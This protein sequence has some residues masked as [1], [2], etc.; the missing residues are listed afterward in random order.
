MADSKQAPAV[1]QPQPVVTSEKIGEEIK[2]LTPVNTGPLLLVGA[3]AFT[4][5]VLLLLMVLV[6]NRPPPAPLLPSPLPSTTTS[7]ASP[8][9]GT[10]SEIARTE[11]FQK[12]E[13]KLNELR[14]ANE[15][16]D[17]S[18]SP[19]TFPLLDMQVNFEKTEFT[20]G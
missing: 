10:V 19:L 20:A 12:F 13:Q 18:E 17:L 14:T 4:V 16:I 3:A 2:K 7:S 1:T 11:E 5:I 8:D 9:S 6:F 15:K